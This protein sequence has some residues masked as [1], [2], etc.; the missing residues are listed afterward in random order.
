MATKVDPHPQSS[1]EPSQGDAYAEMVDR[2]TRRVRRAL[3]PSAT[4]AV[5]SKGDQKLLNIDGRQAWHFPQRAD[6]V[7]AGY[8]PPDGASAID[9]LEIIRE[10]GA[11]FLALPP[12]AVW[13]LEKYPEFGRH[14]ENKYRLLVRD[15]QAGVIFA[16][17]EPGA[18]RDE[19]G[20][21]SSAAERRQPSPSEQGTAVSVSADQPTERYGPPE[22]LVRAELLDD[23]RLLFDPEYYAG[24]AAVTFESAEDALHHYVTTGYRAGL[25]PHPLFDSAWYSKRYPEVSLASVNPLI[26]FLQ[27]SVTDAQDPSPYFDTEYYYAQG[28]GLRE[29]GVNALAHY[30][31]NSPADSAY[32]PNPLFGGG[33]YLT[34][35]FDA[36]SGGAVPLAHYL[37]V[38]CSEGRNVSR[39]HQSIAQQIQRSSKGALT[40]GNWRRGTV[41]FF[42]RGDSGSDVLNVA[43][44]AEGLARD[45]R[46]DSVVLTHERSGLAGSVASVAN[47]VILDDFRVA[48]EIFRPS[49]LRMLAKTLTSL[50]PLFAVSDVPEV[51][52]ALQ[53]AGIGAYFAPSGAR[54]GGS[55][56]T[57][58]F[59]QARRVLLPSSGSFHAAAV[60]LGRYP[61]NVAVYRARDKP[62]EIAARALMEL[63]ARDFD[64]D[65]TILAPKQPSSHQASRTV[66]IPCSDW[67]VSGVN[68]SLQAI[69]KELIGLGWDV[70][71]LF[72]RDES[73]VRQSAGD[74]THL[75]EIPYR[76]L[77]RRGRGLQ[78]M[79][80]AL[81]AEI[82]T[83][84]PCIVFM[85]YDFL[86]NG[87]AP[88]L[89]ENVGVVAWVQADDG[90]YYEQVY[91]LGRYCN[92]VVCV[93]ECI[94]RN[95]TELHPVIGKRAFVIHNSSVRGEEIA[96]T[97]SMRSD[98]LRI[99]YAGRL[100]QY[101]KRVLDYVEL[102]RALDRIAVPYTISLI[103]TFSGHDNAQGAFEREAKSHLEDGRIRLLGRMP[104]ARILETLDE[105]DL[106]VLLSDF[107]GFPLA[108]VEAMARGCVPVVAESM[109]GI[110]EL[111]KDGDN[112]RIIRGRDYDEW[113]RLVTDL[114]QDRRRLSL[115][116]KRARGTVRR[117]FTVERA[118]R[119]FD[120]LFRRVS[121]EIA[122]GTYERPP[123]LN[124]GEERSTTG[125]VLPPPSLLRPAAVHIAGLG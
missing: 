3:P 109:S 87:V 4:V 60:E 78:G 63:A 72:T 8:Y 68:A 17:F 88:A 23:L 37:Q 82:E 45:Y 95:V 21:G 116:A 100:V 125:D 90:D 2:F 1:C 32:R 107:E 13:W 121:D 20:N 33:Y 25:D 97:R 42:M 76:F 74:E 103:G 28:P 111:V 56:C 62:S 115:M 11:D 92:A 75:P 26:H 69:G 22:E 49:A 104:R 47:V 48:C 5:V 108:L 12:S 114:W 14:L 10:K 67:N 96:T 52:E 30:V 91:R 99:V 55:G 84:A 113:A 15:D 65:P 35:Y 34:A 50:S 117:E 86:A 18:R 54:P 39:V 105:Q 77:R 66:L 102:A 9:H 40:R 57:E 19:E 58:A 61:T 119:K 36:R 44:V 89:T 64:L 59:E 27:H 70:E 112:G 7:Y 29:N 120:E 98:T 85:G 94:R 106:F 122:A 80:E 73:L 81:L 53:I 41:L 6:G 124:W 46:L 38:G 71:I 118:A 101:Q 79:W 110:P 93:S 123:S 83:D 43:A 51:L 24:Q 31:K 16:L